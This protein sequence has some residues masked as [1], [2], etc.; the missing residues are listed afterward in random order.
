[1]V[2]VVVV[3]TLRGEWRANLSEFIRFQ[4]RQAILSDDDNNNKTIKKQKVRQ[5]QLQ[6]EDCHERK[7]SVCVFSISQVLFLFFAKSKRRLFDLL[8]ISPWHRKVDKEKSSDN[9]VW[10]ENNFFILSD[11]DKIGLSIVA[12]FGLSAHFQN[13]T[14]K[15]RFF[16]IIF[17]PQQM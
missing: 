8:W 17:F 10:L 12:D 3:L 7:K 6:S 11:V 1:M 14:E 15:A 5:K 16:E 4:W 2:A 9:E 13:T